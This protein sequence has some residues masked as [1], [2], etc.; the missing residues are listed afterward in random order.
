MVEFALVA[1]VFFL[2][3]M[4]T[5]DYGGY[6]G[7]RLAVEEAARAGARVAAVQV[8]GSYSG[9]AIVSAI[10]GQEGP[11]H[12]PSGAD[13]SWRG[14]TLD[15]DAYPPFTFTG[16]GCIG[17]WYFGLL[18]QPNG[19]PTLCA[20]WSVQT[21]SWNTWTWTNGVPSEQTGQSQVPGGCVQPGQDIVVVGV[22]YHYDA[23]T[24]LPAIGSSALDTYGE[25]QLVE[26]GAATG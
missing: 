24:P 9:D 3:V 11:A 17:I 18:D 7:D 25:T 22:G 2:V 5:I 20:Q 4:A 12:L 8:Q 21:S 26:E 13:C 16:S 1:P 6:F 23:F 10:V 14:T 15:A 19:P